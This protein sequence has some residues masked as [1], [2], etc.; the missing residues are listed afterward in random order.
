[1]TEKMIATIIPMAKVSKFEDD[2]TPLEDHNYTTDF[3]EWFEKYNEINLSIVGEHINHVYVKCNKSM[4]DYF[5]SIR[6]NKDYM[7]GVTASKDGKL[8][9]AKSRNA[10]TPEEIVDFLK[11]NNIVLYGIWIVSSGLGFQCDDKTFE[12]DMS[13]IVL[14]TPKI[15]IRYALKEE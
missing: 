15:V 14:T 6:K 4:C 11:N 10:N 5:H 8:Y 9:L 1:M 2:N 3:E 13:K 12:P 7:Y